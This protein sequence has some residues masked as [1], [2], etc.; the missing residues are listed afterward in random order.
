MTFRYSRSGSFRCLAA[1]IG[2]EVQI[3]RKRVYRSHL[4]W[5]C[6]S[7]RNKA[8][9]KSLEAQIDAYA[10]S[11]HILTLPVRYPITIVSTLLHGLFNGTATGQQ[12]RR[13]EGYYAAIQLSYVAE[14]LAKCAATPI[15]GAYDAIQVFASEDP[16]WSQVRQLISYGNFCEI[17]PMVHRGYYRVEGGASSGFDLEYASP[18]F[19]D[20]EA[21][22]TLLSESRFRFSVPSTPS[23]ARGCVRPF[24]G[25]SPG[26]GSRAVYR[27]PNRANAVLR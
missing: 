7:C 5:T 19:R 20:F 3:T 21:R 11:L 25:Y 1:S 9:L 26:T 8:E 24:G 15:G 14:L 17:M 23:P 27:T 13:E 16:N 12:P 4:S 2:G 10:A 6:K 22:D 18:A